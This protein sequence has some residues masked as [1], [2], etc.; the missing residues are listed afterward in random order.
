MAKTDPKEYYKE[1]ATEILNEMENMLI[2]LETAPEDNDLINNV[3]RALHTIKG[4]GSMFGFDKIAAFAHEI[5]TLFDMVRSR[6]TKINR[7]IIDLTLSA[8]DYIRLLL[9]NAD[10]ESFEPQEGKYLVDSIRACTCPPEPTTGGKEKS[11]GAGSA[12]VQ[13]AVDNIN[14]TY[15]I[16][17]KPN[18][19]IFLRGVNVSLVLEELK[20]LGNCIIFA[21]TDNLPVLEEMNPEL[22]YTNWTIIL[23]TGRGLDAIKDVFIF[24][25]DYSEIKIEIIDEGEGLDAEE[26][27]K[28]IGE[29]LY[30]QGHITEQQLNDILSKKE[31]FGNI[32]V[33]KGIVTE[34]KLQSALEE[35]QYVRDLRKK[36]KDIYS[37]ASIRVSNEK[38]DNLVDLVGELVTLQ[39]RLTQRTG[40][41]A[42]GGNL[43]DPELES[44]SESFERLTSEL[45]DNT[46]NL[47]MVPLAET[48]KS[49]YRLVRDLSNELG[50]EIDI[51]TYGSETEL[52]KN[53]IESLKDPL[54]HI[55]RNSVDHGIES[56]DERTRK[57]KP[58]KGKITLGAEYS[59]ANVLIKVSDDGKGLDADKIKRKAVEKGLISKDTVLSKPELLSLIFAPGFSTA[60]KTTSVSGR[61]VGMDV[62]K[63]N[64]ERL[65]GSIEV[66]SEE[67]KG[68]EIILKI[69]LTLSIIDSLLVQIG[70]GRY[71]INLSVVEECV[72]LTKDIVKDSKNRSMAII[73]GEL[74]PLI[75]LRRIFNVHNQ[76]PQVE[77]V[78]ITSVDNQKVGLIVDEVISQHQTVIKPL[79]RAFKDIDE[80]SGSTIL[81]DG[82][83]ALI[84]DAYRIAKKVEEST[85]NRF[86]TASGVP[87][88]TL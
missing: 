80:I 41:A 52:D 87:V 20:G 60:E 34:D 29:I 32:A 55:I 47:R 73:R 24:I 13:P 83:I 56:A 61:G 14:K 7:H 48:F 65:R 49:F 43:I 1:E 51:A 70:E 12:V 35:Q 36:R 53:I 25:E 82:S 81:G 16:Q 67:N 50:K 74:I 2:E 71:I 9:D 15:R 38:L 76:K 22:C 79:S 46:M 84:L 58:V 86:R 44:I 77:Q 57:G 4:S 8:R 23:T 26:D 40:E 42:Q 75:N 63:K 18:G 39:A 72:D 21:H 59:G 31:L 85:F 37:T 64:I 78:V 69:P 19:E 62:V 10:D 54:V 3:F 5:E 68:T 45:R 27:Y 17:F 11:A 6:K 30:E 66:T 33:E 28:R 88:D